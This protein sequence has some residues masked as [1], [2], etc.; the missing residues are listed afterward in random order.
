M[1]RSNPWEEGPRGCASHAVGVRPNVP[2][3]DVDPVGLWHSHLSRVDRRSGEARSR[4]CDALA[5]YR[6]VQAD[7]DD[8]DRELE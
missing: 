6:I 8:L 3:L 2:V 1:G 5:A 4:F 7:P